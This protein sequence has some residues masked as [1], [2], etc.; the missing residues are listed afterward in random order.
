MFP[1]TNKPKQQNT[2]PTWLNLQ[3]WLKAPEPKDKY[4]LLN[5]LPTNTAQSQ[6]SLVTYNIN[7][8][9]EITHPPTFAITTRNLITV[10]PINDATTL[11]IIGMPEQLQHPKEQA[12]RTWNKQH[13]LRKYSLEF[14]A[15]AR[16]NSA[17]REYFKDRAEKQRRT[18]NYDRLF[19]ASTTLER[20]LI[21][22]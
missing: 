21:R 13:R 12:R 3:C 8:G 14:C 2:V 1:L 5:T 11:P 22:G 6:P 15:L 10:L 17:Y 18:R 4:C 7:R 19:L 16:A 20:T 9:G